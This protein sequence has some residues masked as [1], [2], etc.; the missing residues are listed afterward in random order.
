MKAI[1]L[2]AGEGSRLRPYTLDRPK[3]LVEIDGVSLLD[4]QLTVLQSE[5][6]S[7][8]IV[9]SGYRAN[10]LKRPDIILR[11]NL[12][13]NQT[14]MVWSLFCAEQDMDSELVL[15]YGDIVYS[16]KILRT[17]LN[18]NAA[19]SVV[20]DRKW[21]S[22]WELRNENVLEDAETLK[23]DP[24]GHIYEIGNKPNS[25]DEIEG[26]YIGL[27]KL[28]VQGVKIIKKVFHSAQ[29]KGKISGKEIENAYMTDFIQLIIN[30]GYKVKSVP[31]DGDWIEV[32]TARDLKLKITKQRFKKIGAEIN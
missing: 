31:I 6:V 29:M 18:S 14:N 5:G 10:M 26:Q 9:V 16:R 20:I 4:R 28:S 22:Y 12:R 3:C 27:I 24:D 17:I 15:A 11:E 1:I 23:M 25:M 30:E 7:P 19:I 8:V 2:A 13:F 32:D 21:E